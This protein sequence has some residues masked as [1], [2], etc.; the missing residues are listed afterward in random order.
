MGFISRWRPAGAELYEHFNLEFSFVDVGEFGVVDG[1]TFSLA[2]I[3]LI[4]LPGDVFFLT[5]KA[6]L[7]RWDLSAGGDASLDGIDLMYGVGVTAKFTD[8]FGLRGEWEKY[9]LAE[10]LGIGVAVELLSVSGMVFF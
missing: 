2:G 1:E 9:T 7:H 6:G 10:G 4:P 3:G 8:Q 5:A